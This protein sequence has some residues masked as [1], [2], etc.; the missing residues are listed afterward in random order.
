M[1]Y[2]PNR[3]RGKPNEMGILA[4]WG[5]FDAH[6]RRLEEV[7]ADVVLVKEPE[8]LAGGPPLSCS[9]GQGGAFDFADAASLVPIRRGLSLA[10]TC[11]LAISSGTDQAFSGPV[12]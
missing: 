1:N 9:V 4:L 12:V 8:Q 11:D 7:G 3:I 5:I 2:K 6:R 10:V